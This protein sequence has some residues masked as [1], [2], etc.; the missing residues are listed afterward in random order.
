MQELVNTHAVQ[1]DGEDL[2]ADRVAAVQ[3]LRNAAKQWGKTLGQPSPRLELS[4]S[5]HRK[6]LE[7]RSVV[8][9]LLAIPVD[10]RAEGTPVGTRVKVAANV[11]CDDEGRVGLEPVGKGSDWVESAVWSEILLAQRAG[12]W[13]RLKLCREPGCRS[14]FYDT[15]RNHSGVWHNVH[16]CGNITN[17]RASRSRR[18]TDAQ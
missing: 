14:A 9:G 18:K 13:S 4:E 1:R 12:T 7:L 5:D 16:I 2:L 11:V 6:L 10:Q 3:W 17:L 15:S 8:A